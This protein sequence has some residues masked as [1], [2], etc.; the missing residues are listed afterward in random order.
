MRPVEQPQSGVHAWTDWLTLLRMQ[1]AKGV[2][3]PYCRTF[4][5][6]YEAID[7]RYAHQAS[8]THFN[9]TCLHSACLQTIPH[10]MTRTHGVFLFKQPATSDVC[11]Q[12]LNRQL[13]VSLAQSDGHQPDRGIQGRLYRRTAI[14]RASYI[15][16]R[17]IAR[18]W[19]RFA[20]LACSSVLIQGQ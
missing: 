17:H 2:K 15:I 6:R 12:H 20:Y 9:P 3:C 10:W 11:C 19:N 5:D 14:T 13:D 8:A 16:M 7:R 4:V 18:D 1:A